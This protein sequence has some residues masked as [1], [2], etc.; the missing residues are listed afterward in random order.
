M[1][2]ENVTLK[3]ADGIDS[4]DSA[5]RQAALLT[6]QEMCRLE[7]LLLP[8]TFSDALVQTGKWLAAMKQLGR[9]KAKQALWWGKTRTPR[10]R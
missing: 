10:K 7:T 6:L 4:D 9:V 1:P 5:A 3:R 8:R 2:A